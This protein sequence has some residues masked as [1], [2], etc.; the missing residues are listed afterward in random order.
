MSIKFVKFSKYTF[1]VFRY[2][3]I[4]KILSQTIMLKQLGSANKSGLSEIIF[5]IKRQIG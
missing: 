4:I 5:F 3:K 2:K 1:M